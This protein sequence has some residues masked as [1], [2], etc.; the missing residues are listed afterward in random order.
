LKNYVV[1][2]SA[3][4]GKTLTTQITFADFSQV[5]GKFCRLKARTT[6]RLPACKIKK[7]KKIIYKLK[8]ERKNGLLRSRKFISVIG[9]IIVGVF[10][11][12]EARG[13][14]AYLP[15]VGSPPLR[16]Q[17]V[18]TNHFHFNLESFEATEE[19]VETS[20][21][22][23]QLDAPV[24]NAANITAV[25][26]PISFSSAK[27]NQISAA[28]DEENNSEMPVISPNSSSSASDL[29]TV[30]PQMITEYLQPAQKA[31]G[32]AYRKNQSDTSVFVPFEMQFA[33]PMPG[34][35][36]KSQAIYNNNAAPSTPTTPAP[37][38]PGESQAI[39]NN[40]NTK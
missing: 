16:F 39:Y 2:P 30:T 26:T 36:A 7:N 28:T 9:A 38:A 27:T 31:T 34:A 33:P 32:G 6:C 17:A 35:S 11:V 15:I 4:F 8:K 1:L 19:S 37:A 22:V 5:P 18:I 12:L 40:Y 20:N 10:A 3:V 21:T 13:V 14:G 23:A 24:T 25:S 29:L